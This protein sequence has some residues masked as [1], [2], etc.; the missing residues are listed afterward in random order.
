MTISLCTPHFGNTSKKK[1]SV[2]H[3]IFKVMKIAAGTSLNKASGENEYTVFLYVSCIIFIA[4]TTNYCIM[5]L[6]TYFSGLVV[7]KRQ[8]ESQFATFL[9]AIMVR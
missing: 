4:K 7:D 8:G 9:V 5:S 1:D 3:Y 6:M 2:E